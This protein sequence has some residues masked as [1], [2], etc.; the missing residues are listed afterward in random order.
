MPSQKLSWTENKGENMEKILAAS[1]NPNK[2]REIKAILGDMYQV[3]SLKEAGVESDPEETGKTFAENALIKARA[4]MK[5]S[6]MP[7]IADDSGL[8]VEALHGAPGVYSARYSGEGATDEK[9]N[10]LLMKNLE[11]VTDRRAKFVSAIAMVFPDGRTVTAEGECP[12]TVIDEHRGNNGFGYDPYFL[13][14]EYGKTFAELSGD[15]KNRISHRARALE[16]FRK[17]ITEMKGK[18]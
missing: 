1:N 18:E 12:G 4:G 6:G 15:I 11:G 3:L 16:K 14:E 13:V 2:I 5:A 8:C 9:N 10:A 7:C 17:L